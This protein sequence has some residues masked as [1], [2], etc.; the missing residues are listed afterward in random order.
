V[1]VRTG[2]G[3]CVDCHRA[4]PEFL[5]ADT[6]EVDRGG[7]V[8]AGRLGSVGVEAVGGDD[9]VVL[10]FWSGVGGQWGVAAG[11]HLAA[12]TV[13]FLLGKAERARGGAGWVYFWKLFIPM[14]VAVDTIPASRWMSQEREL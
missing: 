10:P 8:H 14:Y 4:G 12:N 13:L 5:G 9:G 1:V 11:C 6:C 7:A 2:L 3:V